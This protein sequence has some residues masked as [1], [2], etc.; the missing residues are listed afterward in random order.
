MPNVRFIEGDREWRVEVAKG[1]SLL[2]AAHRCEAPVHTLCNGV[3]TCVQCKVRVVA[4]AERLSVPGA[5]E[6]DRLGNIFHLTGERMGCQARVEGDVVIECLPV[7]MPKRS[8]RPPP[9][10]R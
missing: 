6:R 7:R 9:T 10:R 8:R 4:G 2:Q 3:G 5:L 1:E